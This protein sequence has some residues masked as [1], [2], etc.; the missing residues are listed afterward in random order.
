[1]PPPTDAGLFYEYQAKVEVVYLVRRRAELFS[2]NTRRDTSL[3]TRGVESMLLKWEPRLSTEAN[4]VHY[5]ASQRERAM[6][7]NAKPFDHNGIDILGVTAPEDPVA[8]DRWIR[9]QVQEALDDPRP[10]VP[11]EQVMAELD[12]VI[13]ATAARGKGRPG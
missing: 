13:K 12:A 5:I 8:R 7:T 3:T 6:T 11:H 4:A 10:A 2:R 9:E 1:M